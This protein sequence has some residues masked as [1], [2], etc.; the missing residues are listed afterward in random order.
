MME[1]G[2]SGIP[3]RVKERPAAVAM[4]INHRH[5]N[6]TLNRALE[7]VRVNGS[8]LK[9]TRAAS[10]PWVERIH[11]DSEK[12]KLLLVAHFPFLMA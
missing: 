4:N 1:A 9:L 12:R 10:L 3:A 5:M 7:F 11:G 6:A 2:S 8:C